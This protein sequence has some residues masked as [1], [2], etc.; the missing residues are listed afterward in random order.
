MAEAPESDV[1]SKDDAATAYEVPDIG[2]ARC[3]GISFSTDKLQDPGLDGSKLSQNPKEAGK[4]Q[5]R[6]VNQAV[7]P[8]SPGTS[9]LIVKIRARVPA[10]TAAEATVAA[11]AKT[12]G[13]N[14]EGCRLHYEGVLFARAPCVL[15]PVPQK[16]DNADA[17]AGSPRQWIW[18]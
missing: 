11:T 4:C 15:A 2:K 16:C 12:P 10:A 13:R 3:R 1:V 6:R 14:L 9:A 7:A 17:K 8:R 18:G 5:A